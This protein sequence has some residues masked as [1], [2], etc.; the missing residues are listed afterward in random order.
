MNLAKLHL[1]VEN[2]FSLIKD[3]INTVFDQAIERS[4]IKDINSTVFIKDLNTV[5]KFNQIKI[6]AETDKETNIGRP[7]I[8]AFTYQP[9][10]PEKIAKIEII[11]FVPK[12][13][14]FS[15][16]KE[17]WEFFRYRFLEI[18]L[19]ELVHRA[20]YYIGKCRPTTL[21]YKPTSDAQLNPKLME[22]Q[23]YLGEIDEMESYSRDCVEFW[24]YT[25]PDVKLTMAKL[26]KEFSYETNIHSL[27]YYFDAYNGDKKHPAV[28]RFFRKC[29]EWSKLI[30]PLAN[31][32]PTCPTNIKNYKR[33][34][35]ITL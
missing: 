22:E 20:Q 27:Q 23:Q 26:K 7:L 29:V 14:R 15:L 28:L 33:I 16:T 4:R 21:M 18:I 35:P 24:A 1:F 12:Q 19:H 9:N 30:T 3:K 2:N 5:L 25:K 34:K 31:Q 11:I 6:L 32:L 10:K 13:R 8:G 17:N